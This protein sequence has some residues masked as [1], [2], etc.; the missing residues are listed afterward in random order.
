MIAQATSQPRLDK[1]RAPGVFYFTHGFAFLPLTKY[2]NK[3]YPNQYDGKK[4]TFHLDN[5]I[6]NETQFF[7]LQLKYKSFQEDSLLFSRRFKYGDTNLC[8]TAYH[9]FL[10]TGGK[11]TLIVNN[12]RIKHEENDAI[13]KSINNRGI[14]EIKRK[15]HLGNKIILLIKY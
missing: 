6:L 8:V 15:R 12:I 11:L 7:N 14:I 10:R 2:D 3:M 5:L 1:Q 4:D 13:I 9:C